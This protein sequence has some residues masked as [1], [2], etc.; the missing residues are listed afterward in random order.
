MLANMERQVAS[1]Q[2]GT[3]IPLQNDLKNTT[4]EATRKRDEAQRTADQASGDYDAA[5]QR[6]KEAQAD[7]D[8]WQDI[9]DNPV[10]DAGATIFSW[11][12]V[13]LVSWLLFAPILGCL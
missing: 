9:V 6:R 3:I 4:D 8:K 1:F 2:S 10:I 11:T 7:V 13:G 5:V 12:P